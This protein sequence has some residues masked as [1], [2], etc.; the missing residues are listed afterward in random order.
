MIDLVL[1]M[2]VEPGFGGQNFIHGMLPKIKK[3][4]DISSENHNLI[5]S[6][7]GGINNETA[8]ECIA[9]GANMLVSGSY[10]FKNDNLSKAIID[11][12]NLL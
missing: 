2:T 6:V 7:D 11:L 1:V 12:R 3:V 9:N 5:I 8:K 10:L 4:H